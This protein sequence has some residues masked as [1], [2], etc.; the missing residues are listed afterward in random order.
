MPNLAIVGYGKMGK[1]I[2]HLAPEYGFAVALKLDEFNNASGEGLTAQNFRGVDVAVDFS[3]PSAVLQNAEA[4]AGLGVNMVI[5]T[6]GWSAHM[7]PVKAAVARAG[8]GLVWSPNYSV[9]VNAFFRLVSEAARLLAS[10]P[11]YGA[12][13]WEIHHATK[14]DAP[15]GTLL[16]L[17]EDMKKAGYLRPVDVSS[18]RAGTVPGTHE[19]GFDSAA[20][21]ITLRHTARSREGFARG[22][23]K[24][25]QWVIGKKGFYEFSDV[26]FS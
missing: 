15:S 25:A 12:W 20:D 1:L 10:Q 4:I 3:I 13:A 8:T 19:I 23:M 5:G 7:E 21:T 24:A 18:N 26:V 6:T 9:G 11:E 17:V 14:K 16:K 2:E 22:A